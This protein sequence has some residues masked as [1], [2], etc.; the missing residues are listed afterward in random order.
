MGLAAPFR[1]SAN[2]RDVAITRGDD[3]FEVVHGRPKPRCER[4]SF[5]MGWTP[6]PMRPR[7]ARVEVSSTTRIERGVRH[8][9]SR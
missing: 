2:E 1:A 5:A 4:L 6:H 9:G 8:A 7:C 3:F